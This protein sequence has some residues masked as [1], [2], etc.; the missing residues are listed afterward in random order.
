MAAIAAISIAAGAALVVAAGISS[1]DD[2][3]GECTYST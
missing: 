1:L 3:P 2:V